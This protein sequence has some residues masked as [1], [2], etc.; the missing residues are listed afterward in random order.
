MKKI[1]ILFALAI[2]SFVVAQDSSIWTVGFG[3]NAIDNTSTQDA[4]YFQTKD[5]NVVPVLSKFSASYNVKEHFAVGAE[6][7]FNKYLAK[8]M[9]NGVQGAI[10]S[11]LNFIAVDVN[12]KYSV[13]HFFTQS[14]WFDAS[15]IGGVGFFWLGTEANQSLNPGVA[16]D[17]WLG[18]G[19]GIRLQTLGRVALDNNKLGNNHIQHSVE[20]I[21]K[22]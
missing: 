9:H 16:L 20:F 10:S 22:F 3:V 11:D 14:K 8:N 13:D 17:F 12:T 5:W 19:Y 21:L 4:V 1:I 15:V 2:S 6:V 18:D 7:A